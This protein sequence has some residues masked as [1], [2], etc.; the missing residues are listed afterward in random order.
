LIVELVIL[1]LDGVDFKRFQPGITV[2]GPRAINR[3]IRRWD[4]R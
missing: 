4:I 1:N 2:I 3:A